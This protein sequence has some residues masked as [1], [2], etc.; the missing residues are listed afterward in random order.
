MSYTQNL[1]WHGSRLD[2]HTRFPSVEAVTSVLLRPSSPSC[3]PFVA[4]TLH[5][6]SRSRSMGRQQRKSR[7]RKK[8]L[9]STV[10]EIPQEHHTLLNWLKRWCWETRMQREES[11]WKDCTNRICS[12]AFWSGTFFFLPSFAQ[13]SQIKFCFK[14]IFRKNLNQQLLF[15]GQVKSLALSIICLRK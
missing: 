7:G 15:L 4:L 9:N 14:I 12:F 13:I 10:R 6:G 3:A 8:Y 1:P 5:V 2:T 11:N